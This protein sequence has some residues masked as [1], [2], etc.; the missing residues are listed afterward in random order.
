MDWVSDDDFRKGV[1]RSEFPHVAHYL[2]IDDEVLLFEAAKAG[3]GIATLPCFYADRATEL[4]T[5]SRSDP[6]PP[7]QVLAAVPHC[8][9]TISSLV[10]GTSDAVDRPPLGR[11]HP[12]M[13]A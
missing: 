4:V 12:L 13:S 8:A 5:V 10:S 3:C 11:R 7:C 1:K 2:Q 9:T 6:E